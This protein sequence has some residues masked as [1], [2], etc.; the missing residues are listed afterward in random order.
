MNRSPITTHVLDTAKG[1]PAA[2]IDVILEFRDSGGW[3]TLGRGTTDRDGRVADLLASEYPLMAGTYRLTF[4]TGDWQKGFYPEVVVTFSVA[5]TGEHYHVPL[6][7][8]PFGYSTY[9]GS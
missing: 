2:G 9:R 8:S 1:K 6:L 7:L 5:S 3:T 4:A